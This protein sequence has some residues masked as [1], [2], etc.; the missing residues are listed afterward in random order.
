ME[1]LKATIAEAR[2]LAAT[3]EGFA[4]AAAR[5]SE[6]QASR[7]RGGD[8]GWS[9][10]GK[11]QGRVPMEV[12]N[13]GHAL[14]SDG[15]MSGIIEAEDGLY[16]VTRTATK[17]PELPSLERVTDRLR[18]ELLRDKRGKVGAAF[19]QTIQSAIPVELFPT[20]LAKVPWQ[21][22]TPPADLPPVNP[23]GRF[24]S[25]NGEKSPSLPDMPSATSASTPIFPP[26]GPSHWLFS[27]ASRRKQTPSSRVSFPGPA[28]R[29]SPRTEVVTRQCV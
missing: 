13:A 27:G 16:L 10:P 14:Q 26:S 24:Q 4:A 3:A 9:E 23:V 15:E 29:S 12:L 6:D 5:F 20:R 18:A 25:I 1:E 11:P 17:M 21:A 2:D 22:T 28:T 19:E 8:I 7:Y